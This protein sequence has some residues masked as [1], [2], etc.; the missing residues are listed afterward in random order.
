MPHHVAILSIAYFQK[1]FQVAYL[2]SDEWWIVVVFSFPV[3]IVDEVLKIYSRFAERQAD[4]LKKKR[5]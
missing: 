1:I 2:T 5:D 4:T 3:I